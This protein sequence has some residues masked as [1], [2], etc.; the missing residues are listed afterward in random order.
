MQDVHGYQRLYQGNFLRGI[1]VA[2]DRGLFIG[3]AIGDNQPWIPTSQFYT[4]TPTRFQADASETTMLGSA[5]NVFPLVSDFFYY[6]PSEPEITP[7]VM[8]TPSPT[9]TPTCPQLLINP[10]FETDAAWRMAATTHPA[11]YSTRVVHSG[12]RSLRAGID[13]TVDKVSYS[14][15]YQDVADPDRGHRRDPELLV[16][17]HLGGR[18]DGGR[19]GCGARTRA[20]PGGDT[21]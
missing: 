21:R 10:G 5:N 19:G 2:T 7:T 6:L 20:R 1:L 11:G 16:A 13:G 18:F 8:P 14:S 15:G 17:P 12:L 3:P 4:T 9:A